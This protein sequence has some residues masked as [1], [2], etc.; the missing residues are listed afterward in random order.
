MRKPPP[1]VTSSDTRTPA[2][3]PSTA[4][5]EISGRF[6]G[7]SARQIAPA[8]YPTGVV[9]A[10]ALAAT[11]FAQLYKFDHRETLIV[12]HRIFRGHGAAWRDANR[13]H[14]SLDQLKVMSAIELPHGRPRRA[15]GTL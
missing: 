9:P 7:A 12:V 2:L 6:P 14:V 4:F 15:C 11:F 1:A 10:A 3:G 13:G 8:S 5:Y